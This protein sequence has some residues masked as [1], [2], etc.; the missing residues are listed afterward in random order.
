VRKTFDDVVS[1]ME[2]DDAQY[3]N[4]WTIELYDGSR[5]WLRGRKGYV[6]LDVIDPDDG[7]SGEDVGMNGML[8]DEGDVERIFMELLHR[9]PRSRLYEG[10]DDLMRLVTSLRSVIGMLTNDSPGVQKGLDEVRRNLR[11]YDGRW[12]GR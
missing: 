9:H 10:D 8:D 2:Q 12:E 3:G 1:F 7:L 6:W 4:S 11:V 5:W